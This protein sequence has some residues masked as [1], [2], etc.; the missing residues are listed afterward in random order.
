MFQKAQV[1]TEICCSDL[2]AWRRE[3]FRSNEV[4]I[5]P[6]HLGFNGLPVP[7][8]PSSDLRKASV[9]EVFGR[10]RKYYTHGFHKVASI[11]S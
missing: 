1:H 9:D 2:Q 7:D 5:Y 3:Y 11:A 8:V 4:K 6:P 10:I